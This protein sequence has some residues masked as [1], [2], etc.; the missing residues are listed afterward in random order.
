MRKGGFE[1][2]P[3][4]GPDPK[5]GASANSATFARI[6]YKLSGVRI[7]SVNA[8]LPREVRVQGETVSTGIFK[9]PVEGRVRIERLNIAG[10]RQ[11]DLSVHGGANKAVYG[12]PSE[13]YAYWAKRLRRNDLASTSLSVFDGWGMFGENLTFEGLLEDAIHLGDC[14]RVGTAVLRVTQP[15][16]P[17]YKLGIR[18]G[19]ADM[20]KKFQLSGRSGFYFSV[21]EE[22]EVAAGDSAEIVSRDKHA[23]TVAECVELYNNR[24]NPSPERVR[25]LL[26]VRALPPGMR[27]FF[28]NRLAQQ[29]S[30]PGLGE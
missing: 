28:V 7:I 26:Q 23:V 24:N 19:R 30:R 22:G 13:H 20:V 11:A 27:K 18:F 29:G 8:G 12:Y 2:P 9:S 6:H 1:P 10:D 5:S 3:L 21:I 25:Q 17:C 14:L 15:R 4:A 16:F